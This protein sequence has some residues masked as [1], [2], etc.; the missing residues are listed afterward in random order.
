MNAVT[1]N[2]SQALPAP[3]PLATRYRSIRVTWGHVVAVLFATLVT[4]ILDLA[5]LFDKL[6]KPGIW[7]AIAFEP[8]VSL[9]IFTTAL[10]AW[11]VFAAEPSERTRWGRLFAA[12]IVS[13]ALTA[14]ITMPIGSALGID[15]VWRP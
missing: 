5:Y 9:L 11:L 7:R 12:S 15:Q 13:A 1:I 4:S 10:L 14:A 8:F 6:G 2:P 3:V